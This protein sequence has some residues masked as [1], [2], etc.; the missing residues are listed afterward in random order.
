MLT[1]AKQRDMIWNVAAETKSSLGNAD[2]TGRNLDRAGRCMSV[3]KPDLAEWIS[4]TK[5]LEN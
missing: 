3:T 5:N 2:N 1:N 4:T